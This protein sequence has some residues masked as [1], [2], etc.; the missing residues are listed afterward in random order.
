MLILGA[1]VFRFIAF[2]IGIVS[3]FSAALFVLP[4]PGKTFFNK[5]SRLNPQA[6]NLIDDSIDL[7]SA[8]FKVSLTLSKEIAYRS[9]LL[10]KNLRRHIRRLK[11]RYYQEL[12]KARYKSRF[13]KTV[14][15]DTNVEE[16][17]V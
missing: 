11:K 14:F 1:K 4:L 3:G 7:I 13:N 17:A 10:D 6:K 9:K 12:D 15:D 5:M 2:I 8:I 16:I